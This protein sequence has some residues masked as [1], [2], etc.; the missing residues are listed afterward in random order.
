MRFIETKGKWFKFSKTY[1]EKKCWNS[2][3]RYQTQNIFL[4][5]SL[6]KLPNSTK[7]EFISDKKKQEIFFNLLNSSHEFIN[8]L[9]ETFKNIYLAI[10]EDINL[11]AYFIVVVNYWKSKTLW[12]SLCKWNIR[13]FSVLFISNTTKNLIIKNI[14]KK[15][16]QTDITKRNTELI[17]YWN[18]FSRMLQ[19]PEITKIFCHTV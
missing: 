9:L 13:W 2:W 16:N 15:K 19:I 6:E 1:V 5:E 14:L 4:N 18:L 11:W 17:H 7:I 12:K 10:E 3:N 8:D